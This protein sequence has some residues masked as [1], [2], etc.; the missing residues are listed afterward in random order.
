MKGGLEGRFESL[1]GQRF[2]QRDGQFRARLLEVKQEHNRRGILTSSITIAAMHAELEREFERSAAECAKTLAELMES[3][4]TALLVPRKQKVLRLCSDA[5]LARKAALEATCQG[6]SA[7]IAASLSSGM[8]APH[9]TL[10]DSFVQLQTENACVE[11]RTKQRE[12]FWSKLKRM[13]LG[14]GLVLALVTGLVGVMSYLARAELADR[15]N[16]F[17]GD[18]EQPTQGAGEV[19]GKAVPGTEDAD[20][21][22]A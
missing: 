5:L 8:I 9:R 20:R 4:P 22:R 15:W 17:R 11:L 19:P 6:A 13:K 16:S 21:Q 10:S 2:Q 7:T 3:R 12:L 18:V 1:I 14:A